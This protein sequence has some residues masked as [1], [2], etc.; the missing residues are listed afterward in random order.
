MS[1]TIKPNPLMNAIQPASR[2]T[3][4]KDR[5]S[6]ALGRTALYLM[7]AIGAVIITLPTMWLLS[8]SLKSY[9]E[10]HEFPVKF[11]PGKPTLE[12]YRHVLSRV[13][14]SDDPRWLLNTVIIGFFVEI[15]TLISNS[16]ASFFGINNR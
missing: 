15:G 6:R 12:A 13:Q 11:L 1:A 5:M 2:H 14:G 7:L 3:W 9:H 16:M 8:S 4:T 10:I